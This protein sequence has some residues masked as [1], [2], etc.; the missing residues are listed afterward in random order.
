MQRY[1]LVLPAAGML[2]VGAARADEP[3]GKVALSGP[4]GASHTALQ[5]D[6]ARILASFAE[7]ARSA[8]DQVSTSS[9]NAASSRLSVRRTQ[10]ATGAQQP[11]P[12]GMTT[13]P[14]PVGAMPARPVVTISP[15]ASWG[16]VGAN[17]CGGRWSRAYGYCTYRSYGCGSASCGLFDRMFGCCR[18]NCYRYGCAEACC[19]SAMTCQEAVITNPRSAEPAPGAA[20]PRKP[21]AE[22]AAPKIPAAPQ[23]KLPEPP[24]APEDDE[25][26]PMPEA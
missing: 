23:Q 7:V 18:D 6:R 19:P 16:Y 8:G 4:P 12:L 26:K 13:S 1:L 14:P 24:P 15:Y 3:R 9:R 17:A 20:Q 10:Y 2:F 22:P 21:A 11:A 25:V 5:T